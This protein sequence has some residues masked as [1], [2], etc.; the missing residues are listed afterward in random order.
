MKL[1]SVA[2]LIIEDFPQEVRS[3]L[4]KLI[5]PLND[6]LGQVSGILNRGITLRDNEK[7]QVYDVSI[8]KSAS[9]PLKLAYSLNERPTAVLIGYLAEDN[10]N[11]SVPAAAYSVHWIYSGGRLDITFIGL[12]STKKFKATLIAKV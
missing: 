5:Q 3:W 11:Q 6:H 2:R 9:Y 12:D 10:A 8:P 7:A 4:P 1:S